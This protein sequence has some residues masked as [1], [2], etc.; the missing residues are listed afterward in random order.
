M[1]HFG[2]IER[3]IARYLSKL[4]AIKKAVKRLYQYI[5]YLQN[6]N[7]PKFISSVSIT[8]VECEG[9][10]FFGYYDK[11]PVSPS[12]LF[13][14]Y[15]KVKEGKT[16]NHP[17]TCKCEL[18]VKNLESGENIVRR[19][20]NAF[21][22]QQGNKSF[23]IGDYRLIFNDY[24]NSQYRAVIL[25]VQTG[26]EEVID[27][28][29]YDTL[30]DRFVLSISFDRLTK[31]RPDYGYFCK[32]DFSEIK[33][34]DDDGIY[35][36]DLEKR[37]AGKKLCSLN[38]VIRKYP[39]ESGA[40][41]KLEQKFNHIMASPEGNGFIVLHR[42]YDNG[43]RH[44]RLIY[45]SVDTENFEI[46]NEVMLCDSGMV[47]H[48]CWIDKHNVL[49][50]MRLGDVD[51]YYEINLQS[52]DVL[53]KLIS[54]EEMMKYGDG[55]PTSLNEEYFITDTY[56]DKSRHKKVLLINRKSK[57]ITEV[58]SLFEPL[59]FDGQTRCDLHPKF[60]PERNSIYIEST[61][62]GHRRLYEIPIN[63]NGR[64]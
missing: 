30:S 13:L 8:P 1:S 38:E 19:D 45:I 23:W 15:L 35:I 2:V 32:N 14:V 3:S 39:F 24:I 18:I 58:A 5:C 12:G 40:S 9:E 16:S 60:S 29:V 34:D 10:T 26:Q 46:K 21:N 27:Q 48:C 22:W 4:P 64:P 7:K 11:S 37:N 49:A 33:S 61:H 20:I 47:S 6:F 51:G 43:V 50:Y 53:T 55:H 56:P 17:S 41:K 54:T 44:D 36:Y 25:N 63:E 28:P 52:K 62:S 57:E 31:I 42:I 59:K